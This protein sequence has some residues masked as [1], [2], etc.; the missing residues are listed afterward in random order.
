M[1]GSVVHRWGAR[2]LA[3]VV[4]AAAISLAAGGA[5]ANARI[6]CRPAHGTRTIAHSRN[7]RLFED[8]ANGND[9]ACLYSNGHPRY[10]STTEHYEYPLVRFAGPYVAFEPKIEAVPGDVGVMNMRTGRRHTYA[11]VRPIENKICAEVD[12]LVLKP[13]GAVAWIGTNFLSPLCSHPPGPAIEVRA[14]DRGGLRVLDSGVTI[15]ARSLR[16][17][18]SL[19]R[20]KHGGHIRTATLH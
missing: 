13:D 1:C 18:G 19:L 9:Y 2:L 14:H 4:F 11:A 16:L 6:P 17:S 15:A 10:L 7:A 20:W 12:S 3:P 8:F 5:T